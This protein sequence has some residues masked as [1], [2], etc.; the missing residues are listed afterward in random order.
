MHDQ[1]LLV[2]KNGDTLTIQILRPFKFDMYKEFRA[3]YINHLWLVYH[4]IVDLDKV[5]QLDSSA[6]GM[7]M[8]LHKEATARNVKATVTITNAKP[9]VLTLLKIANLQDIFKIV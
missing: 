8:L 5:D 2:K 6:L 1:T 3:A 7:L 9:Q 4:Y